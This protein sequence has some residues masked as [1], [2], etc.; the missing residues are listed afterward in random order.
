MAWNIKN[1]HVNCQTGYP[2]HGSLDGED[3]RVS[4]STFA[5]FMFCN[6]YTFVTHTELF[7]SC[8]ED[9]NGNVTDRLEQLITMQHNMCF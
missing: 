2:Q 7:S 3:K 1:L 9:A 6:T 8:A 5:L 4:H